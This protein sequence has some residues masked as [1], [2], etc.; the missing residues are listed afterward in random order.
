MQTNWVDFKAIKHAV[1][2]EQVLAHYRIKLKRSGNEL[3]GKCPLH[4]GEGQDTFHASV[5]KNAFHC[6]SCGAKGNVLDFVAAMEHCSVRDAAL[7]LQRWFQVSVGEGAGRPMTESAGRTLQEGE[8]RGEENQPLGFAL[9][10]I[11]HRHQYLGARGIDPETAEYFGAGFYSGRGS[12]HGRIVIPIENEGGQLVAYAGRSIDGS[13]PKYKLPAGFK[14]SQVLYNLARAKDD[15]S[16][17]VIVVEGFFDCMKVTQAEYPCVALMGSQLSLV[18]EQL[19]CQHFDRA[20]LLFDG[21][22]AGQRATE[23]CLLRLGRKLW[24]RAIPLPAGTQPDQLAAEQL[25][26]VLSK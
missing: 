23:D 7:K 8:G 22:E 12:M 25:K 11:D 6:F 15:S 20:L 10:G 9:K 18:Q 2:V 14:K 19:L 26:T 1:T 21:D 17:L 4:Q 16:G 13:E 24:V 5:E 3:R